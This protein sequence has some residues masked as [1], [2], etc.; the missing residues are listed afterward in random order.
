VLSRCGSHPR[1]PIGEARVGDVLEARVMERCGIEPSTPERHTRVQRR[2][3]YQFR[4]ESMAAAN[5]VEEW[6]EASE[7]GAG[8]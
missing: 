2:G 4:I 3:R 8:E 6:V 7:T 5:F 1:D